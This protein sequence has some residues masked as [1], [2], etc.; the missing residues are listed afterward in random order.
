MQRIFLLSLLSI[1]FLS[2][3]TVTAQSPLNG[4]QIDQIEDSLKN[5]LQKTKIDSVKTDI[6]LN[7]INLYQDIQPQK[8]FQWIAI[9]KKISQQNK[10]YDKLLMFS[11]LEM[12]C[13]G[14]LGFFREALVIADNSAYLLKE[15]V[16]PKTKASFFLQKGQLL[17]KID[18]YN[19]AAMAMNQAAE[20]ASQNNM[21][22][23]QVKALVNLALLLEAV[24]KYDEMKS[25]CIKAL[26]VAKKAN[27]GEDAANVMVNLALAESR[28]NN[29]GKAIEYLHEA[30]PYYQSKNN[31]T[32]VALCYANL[33]WGYYQENKYPQALIN[34]DK[35]FTIRIGLNDQAGISKLHINK[36][37][38]F[39]E[40]GK[41]DSSLH[42]LQKGIAI[43]KTL[44]LPQ[45]L[46]DGYK[47]QALLYE[48]TKK[49]EAAYQS[50]QNHYNWKDSIFSKEKQKLL[51]QQLNIYKSKYVD[52]LVLQKDTIIHKQ[53]SVINYLGLLSGL[54]VLIVLVG[55]IWLFKKK[56]GWV[57]NTK[58]QSSLLDADD[59]LQKNSVLKN[60][61]ARLNT[62]IRSLTSSLNEQTS[63]D[64]IKLR[65]LVTESNL[66]TEGYWN[67][68]LLLFSKIYPSFLEELKTQYPQLTQTELRICILIKLSL[69]LL[70]IANLLN[71]TTESARKARY[72]IYKKME[73]S[74][75]KELAEKL[76]I[77]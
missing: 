2:N 64:L 28:T 73:L 10:L 24:E 56:N 43:A 25:Q 14:R 21:P 4:K 53:K 23:V 15:K 38:I 69:S 61:I 7:L 18:N 12:R 29:Y 3:Y 51:M 16:L 30:L 11:V 67:E 76:L 68:F 26:N 33:S 46:H 57:G 34:A 65:K 44:I 70:E 19:Q 48:R 52:S 17:Y 1:V 59:L 35:S 47:S 50:L 58:T 77:L 74:S 54:V 20:I 63:E 32:S 36:G 55:V 13:K 62:E 45:I 72:R 71:I 75:D 40:M 66:Q 49:Y 6:L 60:E 42:H 39:L 31:Y 5:A 37:Q 8:T 41:Y 9:A 27:L 22:N